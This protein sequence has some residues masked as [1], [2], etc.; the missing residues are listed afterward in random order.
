MTS[1][2]ATTR[3]AIADAAVREI[4]QTCRIEYIPAATRHPDDPDAIIPA[5]WYLHAGENYHEGGSQVVLH[6][7]EASDDEGNDIADRFAAFL[8][9]ALKTAAR[10]PI[11]D[12]KDPAEYDEPSR[13]LEQQLAD[14]LGAVFPTDL[15][16][17]A[18][19]EAYGA[20]KYKTLQRCQDTGETPR[21]VL[22]SI[23]AR[24]RA[25]VPDANDPAAFLAS[26]IDS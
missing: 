12:E 15:H 21:Q 13:T 26:R 6:I 17:I 10:N 4:A 22:D 11:G 5:G 23:S 25:F 19:S 20:L 1:D 3:D 7:D 18:S 16:E 24:D 9:T 8:A 14:A 2:D